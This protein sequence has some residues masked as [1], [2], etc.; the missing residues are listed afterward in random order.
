LEQETL[1]DNHLRRVRYRRMGVK[2]PELRE[3]VE[4]AGKCVTIRTMQPGDRDIEDAFVRSLSSGSRY[5]R[6]HSALKQLTPAMLDRFTNVDYPDEM[7]LIATIEEDGG[8]REIA[9]ARYVRAPGTDRAEVAVAVAD[10]WQGKGLG[11]RLLVRLRDVARA[12]G[13]KHLEASVLSHNRRM[14]TLARE[15]GFTRMP[16]QRNASTIALGKEVDSD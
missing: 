7:A 6:F 16:E 12:A 10:D 4:L 14:L 8:E 15:L 3:V 5:L 1:D 11:T 9:V 13:V 2:P